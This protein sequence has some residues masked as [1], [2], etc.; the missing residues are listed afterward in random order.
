MLGFH[1]I[2]A[3]PLSA[4]K[5]ALLPPVVIGVYGGDGERKRK[6]R[7]FPKTAR[8]E[9]NE[10]LDEIIFPKKAVVLKKAEPAPLQLKA[11][12]FDFDEDDLEMLLLTCH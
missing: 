10:L 7:V 6:K 5:A 8:E 3:Q 12:G 4:L 9:I 2:A 1:P 11:K